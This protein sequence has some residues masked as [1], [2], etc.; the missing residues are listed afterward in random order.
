LPEVMPSWG[1][2]RLESG[3]SIRSASACGDG[4]ITERNMSFVR[5]NAQPESWI[6]QIFYGWLE[7]ILVCNLANEEDLWGP[8]AGQ[9]RLLAVITPCKTMGHDT[10]K[11]ITSYTQM[12]TTI[13]TDLQ[14]VVAVVGCVQTRGSWWI[15]DRT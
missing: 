9:K 4:S 6:P 5:A 15:I 10:A 12:T 8:M 7:E 13:V 3:D 14:S 1:K 2:V 11:E